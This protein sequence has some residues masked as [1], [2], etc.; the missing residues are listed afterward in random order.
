MPHTLY[1]GTS[2]SGIV[3][4][5]VCLSVLRS[6]GWINIYKLMF[7]SKI[8]QPRYEWLQVLSL[9]QWLRLCGSV[10]K[11]VASH[12][13]VLGSNLRGSVGKAVA[14]HQIVLGSNLRQ[15]N[16][17]VK[18]WVCFFRAPQLKY[19]RGFERA[20]PFSRF[21]HFCVI[22]SHLEATLEHLF[23]KIITQ[24]ESLE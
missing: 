20:Q 9:V 7:S 8:S 19:C 1:A 21:C 2:T 12:Q 3:C 17:F 5:F 14:S 24:I 11:A 4:V 10:G 22:F 23:G 15:L 13:I 6:S 18:K 16:F